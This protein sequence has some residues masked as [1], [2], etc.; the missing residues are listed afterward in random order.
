MSTHK[1]EARPICSMIQFEQA[2]IKKLLLIRDQ[3]DMLCMI[4][5]FAPEL[6]IH[7]SIT[8]RVLQYKWTKVY[9]LERGCERR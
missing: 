6:R 9:T 8:M 4:V 7:I 2:V 3:F 5:G 1:F